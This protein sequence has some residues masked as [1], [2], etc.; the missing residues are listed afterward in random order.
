[1]ALLT[2]SL[3]CASVGE[4]DVGRR[5]GGEERDEEEGGGTPPPESPE[6]SKEDDGVGGRRSGSGGDDVDGDLP[7]APR[8]EHRATGIGLSPSHTFVSSV[9]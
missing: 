7:P 8:L 2:V 5:E 9:D 1:M 3:L 4:E 6:G